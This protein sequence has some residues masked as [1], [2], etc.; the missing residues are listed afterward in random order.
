MVS[1]RTSGQSIFLEIANEASSSFVPDL[2]SVLMPMNSATSFLGN[3]AGEVSTASG[4]QFDTVIV[5]AS[6]ASELG[7]IQ[8]DS[9]ESLYTLSSF[10]AMIFF[11]NE[12][13]YQP[14]KCLPAAESEDEPVLYAASYC[15][16]FRELYA[17][18]LL[19]WGFSMVSLL[20]IAEATA[21]WRLVYPSRRSWAE[22][23]DG[24]YLNE[25]GQLVLAPKQYSLLD[26]GGGIAELVLVASD[27]QSEE[28]SDLTSTVAPA[29]PADQNSNMTP[30]NLGNQLSSAAYASTDDSLVNPNAP[31]RTRGNNPD[32]PLVV[33]LVRRSPRFTNDGFMHVAI[34]D[35]ASRRRN[36]AV[37]RAT[38][39]E[40]MQL[41]EMQRIGVE[42]C[43]IDPEDLSE[44]N[45]R[46]D[47]RS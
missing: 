20:D 24:M 4:R 22:A 27:L 2:L 6:V 10:Q 23:F 43:G 36:S 12:F 13:F 42:D 35:R 31:P 28:I 16:V 19:K 21:A 33:T 45:L 47:R 11:F 30:F 7:Q 15:Q 29:E 38:A 41:A 40:V 32:T 46:Q 39:P 18:A 34:P 14:V 5:S 17:L 9:S 8:F 26:V 3:V 25:F 44:A 37:P 1:A